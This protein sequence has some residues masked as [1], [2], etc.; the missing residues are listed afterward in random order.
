MNFKVGDKVKIK[1]GARVVLA[2]SC[3]QTNIMGEKEGKTA[4]FEGLSS[5]DN[6]KCKIKVDI[7]NVNQT[8]IA[9]LNDIT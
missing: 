9:D 8:V 7:N 3:Q 4:I 5:E 1:G 6:T 2:S